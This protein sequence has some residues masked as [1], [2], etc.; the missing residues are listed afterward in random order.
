MYIGKWKDLGT[1]SQKM[2]SQSYLLFPQLES[3]SK[4]I[5]KVIHMKRIPNKQ[6]FGFSPN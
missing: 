6:L 1:L 3:F 5:K 4:Q 2:S